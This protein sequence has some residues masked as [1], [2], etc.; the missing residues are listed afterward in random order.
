MS[1]WW[2]YR[3][4]DF[5]LFSPE[6]YYRLLELYNAAI[7][8]GQ[9]LAIVVGVATLVLLGRGGALPGRLLAA[10][11][12]LAWLFVAWAYLYARYATINWAAPY[13]AVGF[14]VQAVLLILSGVVFGRM[15]FRSSQSR[16]LAGRVRDERL[17]GACPTLDRPALWQRMD[18]GGSVRAFSG[19]H[20]C[21]HT[22]DGNRSRPHKHG[23]CSFFPS[24]GAQSPGP[25]CGRWQHPMLGSCRSLQ[26]PRSSC[27]RWRRLVSAPK[28]PTCDFRGPARKAVER[29]PAGCTAASNQVTRAP[30]HAPAL[31]RQR[32]LAT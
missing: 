9:I 27:S 11:L 16:N 22:R 17:R 31:R 29:A 6:T 14:A 26:W 3:L 5:L 13:F 10:I 23:N 24:S 20:G 2:T 4:S 25:L 21:L 19:S 30:C 7:W 28:S 15:S 1:E 32:W 8:P 18:A 12:A